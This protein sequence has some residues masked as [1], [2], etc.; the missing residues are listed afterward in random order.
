MDLPIELDELDVIIESVSDV[1]TEL[2]RKLRL[3]KDV[4][5]ANP[6]GPYKKILRDTYGMVI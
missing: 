5:E 4:R 3:V 6:D 2:C 1:D